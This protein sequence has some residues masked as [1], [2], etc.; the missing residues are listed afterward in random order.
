M[1]YAK[2]KCRQKRTLIETV[3][4]EAQTL[5]LLN[6]DLISAFKYYQRSKGNHVQRTKGN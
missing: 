2:K 6:K 1:R 5:D 4:E 3:Q